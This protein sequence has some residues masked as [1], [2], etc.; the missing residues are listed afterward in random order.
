MAA[1]KGQAEVLK[2]SLAAGANKDA[3]RSDGA[4]PMHIAAQQGHVEVLKMFLAAGLTR[5]QLT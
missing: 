5:I 3:V 2:M 1:A 4:T